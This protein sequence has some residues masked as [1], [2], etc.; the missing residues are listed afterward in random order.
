MGPLLLVSSLLLRFLSSAISPHTPT[1]RAQSPSSNSPLRARASPLIPRM[2]MFRLGSIP[3]QL[4]M[5]VPT[6]TRE[7]SQTD[8]PRTPIY[9][10]EINDHCLCSRREEQSC[11]ARRWHQDWR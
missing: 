7:L 10:H 8:S 6:S 2:R 5:M 11:R 9:L 3:S 1:S 4:V